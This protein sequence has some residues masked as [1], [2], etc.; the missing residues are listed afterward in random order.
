[1]VPT[2]LS[3]FSEFYFGRNS[4][5]TKCL[6]QRSSLFNCIN[7]SF[8]FFNRIKL[9]AFDFMLSSYFRK[10][11]IDDYNS[12]QVAI[13]F[14]IKLESDLYLGMNVKTNLDIKL[15]RD[16]SDKN[17]RTK[18]TI[19]DIL[20]LF[21][22]I[23]SSTLILHS[24]YVTACLGKVIYL[25]LLYLIKAELYS[26]GCLWIIYCM[27]VVPKGNQGISHLIS[28]LVKT[29][30]TYKPKSSGWA[31]LYRILTKSS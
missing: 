18:S 7:F 29:N 5:F 27:P 3:K 23:I 28:C 31:V 1:L 13:T 19:L 16:H 14:S 10:T 12:V 4:L 26:S 22:I 2:C 30:E 15:H 8:D 24:F 11:V 17:F 6:L 25:L 20:V 21:T 9:I